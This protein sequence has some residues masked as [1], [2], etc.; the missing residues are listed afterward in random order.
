MKN[1]LALF[2]INSPLLKKDGDLLSK[3]IRQN[4]NPLPIGNGQVL[5]QREGFARSESDGIEIVTASVSKL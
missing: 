4:K 3:F 1:C 2:Y 5:A